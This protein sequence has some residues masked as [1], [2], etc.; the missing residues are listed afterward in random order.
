MYEPVPSIDVCDKSDVGS[1]AMDIENPP[2]GPDTSAVT[3][4]SPVAGSATAETLGLA[5]INGA[6]APPRTAGV[7]FNAAVG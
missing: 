1:W 4:I 5:S 7:S 3:V 2:A 6:I